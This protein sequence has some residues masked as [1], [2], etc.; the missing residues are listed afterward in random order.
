VA[1]NQGGAIVNAGS[2]AD[3]TVA[4]STITGNSASIGGAIEN[5]GPL[6][7]V[8]D[9]ISG[10]S[11]SVTSSSILSG[12]LGTV[13]VLNT[14]IGRDTGQ[15]VP[16]IE[17]AFQSAGNNIV[18][19]V[20]SATGFSNGVNGDQVSQNNAIDPMLRALANN[21]GQ[22]DTLFPSTTSPAIGNANTCASTGQC[23]LYPS[24]HLY[25]A[26][27]DQRHLRRRLFG[28]EQTDVGAVETDGVVLPY[29]GQGFIGFFGLGSR[30]AGTIVVFID[31]VTLTRRYGRIGLTGTIKYDGLPATDAFVMDIKVKRFGLNV[32]TPFVFARD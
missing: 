24:S 7:L 9:T 32:E 4:S 15:P 12:P 8:H 21:G 29:Q 16:A 22:T 27:T 28:S 20:G 30:F 31:P 25:G 11:A 18:T 14:I 17:G 3:T 2:T 23:P 19:D 1:D 6:W 13:T 5:Q 10:N 26:G